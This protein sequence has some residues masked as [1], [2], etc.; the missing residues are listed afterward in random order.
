MKHIFKH[1]LCRRSVHHKRRSI[2]QF[3]DR[4]IHDQIKMQLIGQRAQNIRH[5]SVCNADIDDFVG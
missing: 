3:S 5:S 1:C 4:W 2:A